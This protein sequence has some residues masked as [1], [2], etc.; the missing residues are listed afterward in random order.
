M[1]GKH[2]I[3]EDVRRKYRYLDLRSDEM[4]HRLRFR[5]T[6][7]H[8]MCQYLIGEKPQA[9]GHTAKLRILFFCGKIQK[10]TAISPSLCSLNSFTI[11]GLHREKRLLSNVKKSLC[12]ILLVLYHYR[13]VIFKRTA[14]STLKRRLCFEKLL[15][16]RLNLLYLRPPC[17]ANF[18]RFLKAHNNSSSLLS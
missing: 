13:C 3:N 18:I 15:V 11:L 14:S 5:S 10:T 1:H 2:D 17:L 16:G 12:H 7:T 4:Q 6:I 9:Q 8:D